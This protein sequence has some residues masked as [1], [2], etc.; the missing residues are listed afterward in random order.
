MIQAIRQISVS[1]GVNATMVLLYMDAGI[2]GW[3]AQGF[4]LECLV[5]LGYRSQSD[6]LSQAGKR[7]LEVKY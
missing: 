4:H 1:I 5:I 7:L 3:G 2:N 6:C